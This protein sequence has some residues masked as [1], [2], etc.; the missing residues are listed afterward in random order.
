MIKATASAIKRVV[1]KMGLPLNLQA[2]IIRRLPLDWWAKSVA[3]Q[4]CLAD[5]IV[6]HSGAV[7]QAGP[8]KGMAY[9]D[10]AIEGCIVPKFLGCYE[11]ELTPVIEEFVQAGYDRV[12]D[13]GCASGYFVSGL[14]RRLPL[15]ETFAFD[16][17]DPARNR[18]AQVVALNK[19]EQRVQLGGLC[20]NANLQSLIQGRTL[21]VIDCEGAEF[22]LLDP[23]TVPAL[24]QCDMII[25][26]HDFI[27]PR[28]SPALYARFSESHSIEKISSRTRTPSAESYPGLKVLPEKH[29][30]EALSERRP[31]VMDW[32]ILRTRQTVA[33]KAASSQP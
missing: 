28:I 25:E 30:P 27:D 23:A 19:L 15:A 13:V 4:Q 33:P 16:T 29:W 3:Y 17:D 32:L 12:I 31:V 22:D 21:L 9:I 10:D 5:R 18:C 20:S 7:V 14:S 26:V 1:V 6:A 11:E 2:G 8:F 24:A